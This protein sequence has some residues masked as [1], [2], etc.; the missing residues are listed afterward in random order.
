THMARASG[1]AAVLDAEALPLSPAA[2][3]A[4]D[5]DPS[6]RERLFA[7]DDYELLFAAPPGPQGGLAATAL[8]LH[9]PLTRL[10]AT[11]PRRAPRAARGPG[12]S[13]GHC[14]GS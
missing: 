14:A 9:L 6:L 12:R 3:A 13:G 1:V 8:D 10:G 4:L 7:G 2:R 5:L 11:A